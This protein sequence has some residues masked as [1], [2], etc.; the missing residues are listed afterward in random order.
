MLN[1]LKLT[2]I[3]RGMHLSSLS[4][5]DTA[6]L[7]S[8]DKSFNYAAVILARAYDEDGKPQLEYGLIDWESVKVPFLHSINLEPSKPDSPEATRH[9]YSLDF[10][11]PLTS[12]DVGYFH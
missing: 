9:L 1:E 11:E 3:E 2:L 4:T 10:Y 8:P 7:T 6:I 5:D 12:I